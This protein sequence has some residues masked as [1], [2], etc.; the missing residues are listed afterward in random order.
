MW[1][2]FLGFHIRAFKP[3]EDVAQA[4]GVTLND[5]FPEHEDDLEQLAGSDAE[6]F[7]EGLSDGP[8]FGEQE[9]PADHFE[10]GGDADQDAAMEPDQREN[11]PGWAELEHGASEEAEADLPV[12]ESKILLFLF[13]F[14]QVRIVVSSNCP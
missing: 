7:S 11:L 1:A 8:N 4:R 3:D 13:H 12:S 6:S 2:V 9:A 10:P 5:M 14:I